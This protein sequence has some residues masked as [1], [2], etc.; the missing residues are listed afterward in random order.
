MPVVPNVKSMKVEF[1][2]HACVALHLSGRVLLI[3]PYES[4]QFKGKMAYAPI[5][6]RVDWVVSTHAHADH[7]AFHAVP[8]A[9]EIADEGQYGPFH[10]RRHRA[11][12]DEYDGRRKGGPVDILE[13]GS[14]EATVVHLSDVGESPIASIASKLRG[15]DLVLVP[16]GGNFTIGAAQAWEWLERLAPRVAV[17]IHYRTGACGLPIRDA[18]A[19]GAW[20]DEAEEIEQY[21]VDVQAQLPRRLI[22]PPRRGESADALVVGGA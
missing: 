7:C 4:G 14:D 15:A 19:F 6:F 8:G 20:V 1:I 10:I 11:W 5:D 17:P 18:S 13:I 21:R 16:V 3:D 9:F 12:H 22:I 2:G